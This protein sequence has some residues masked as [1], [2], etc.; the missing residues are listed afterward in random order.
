LTYDWSATADE[1]RE[2]IG[3]PPFAPE[4][5]TDSLAHLAVLLD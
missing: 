2:L 5:L 3:F 1:T 4:H